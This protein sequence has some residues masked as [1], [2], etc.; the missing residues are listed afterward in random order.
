MD[1]V[2]RFGY[3]GSIGWRNNDG[4]VGEV[5]A[6][7]SGDIQPAKAEV[8]IISSSEE[9]CTM[10]GEVTLVVGPASDGGVEYTEAVCLQ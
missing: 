6:T 8:S 10:V 4:S 5:G 9:T 3:N 2:S 1:M 7:L